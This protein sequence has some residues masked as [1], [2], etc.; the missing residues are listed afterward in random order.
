V[1]TAPDGAVFHSGRALETLVEKIESF[2]GQVEEANPQGVVA[3]VGL[4]PIEDAPRRAAHA[5][6]AIQ[7]IVERYRGRSAESPGARI[8]L[9]VR[10]VLVAWVGTAA[11]VDHAAKREAWRQLEAF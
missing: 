5:A 4:E 10:E 9:H 6:L 1:P 3:V 7:R 8:G 2:G 11:R